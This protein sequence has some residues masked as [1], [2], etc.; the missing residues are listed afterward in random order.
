MTFIEHFTT[1]DHSEVP[2]LLQIIWI[3]RSVRAKRIQHPFGWSASIVIVN[4]LNQRS[5]ETCQSP[6]YRPEVDEPY[7]ITAGQQNVEGSI[8]YEV[9]VKK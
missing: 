1:Q 9:E 6:R 4:V 2:H 5:V 3:D 7:E 8:S